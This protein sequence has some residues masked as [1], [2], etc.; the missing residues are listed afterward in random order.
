MRSAVSVSERSCGRRTHTEPLR[1]L[2]PRTSTRSISRRTSTVRW[3]VD[4]SAWARRDLPGVAN[5]LEAL[6]DE[7]ESAHFVMSP[8]V[9][10]ELLHGPQREDVGS[11]RRAFESEFE[12]LE[13]DAQTFVLAADAVEALSALGPEAHRLPIPD[14]VTAALAHQYGCGVVHVDGD[15]SVLA[16]HSGL[17][18]SEHRIE[19]PVTTGEPGDEHPAADLRAMV[20]EMRQLLHRRPLPDAEAF[21]EGVLQQLRR[22]D[23][24]T[25]P[26]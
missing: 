15:F 17:T 13:T 21:V 8:A 24:E 12:V 26:Q 2:S 1:L 10:L 22:E 25:P 3:I 23:G 7:D 19:L 9:L 6:L 16:Q 4:T 20:K 5:Q 11:L 14:L 18:F